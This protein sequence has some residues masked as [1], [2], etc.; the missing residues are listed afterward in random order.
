MSIMIQYG[1]HNES[2]LTLTRFRNIDV[3]INPNISTVTYASN[4]LHL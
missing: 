4:L 2:T 1:G 3:N